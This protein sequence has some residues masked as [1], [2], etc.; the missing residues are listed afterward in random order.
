MNCATQY[1]YYTLKAILS[2]PDWSVVQ[3]QHQ[4]AHRVIWRRDSRI[5]LYALSHT[6][7]FQ[8][9]AGPSPDNPPY[10]VILLG[11]FELPR[12]RAMDFKSIMATITSQ[13]HYITAF[14]LARIISSMLPF[15]TTF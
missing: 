14:A 10:L 8:D 3:K 12:P 2:Q 4:L 7:G 1:N 9:R 6:I 11:R 5:E 13:S 15:T